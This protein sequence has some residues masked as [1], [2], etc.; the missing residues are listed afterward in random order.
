[1]KLFLG[2]VRGQLL[3]S[4]AA[5]LAILLVVAGFGIKGM[6]DGQAA[7]ESYVEGTAH[8]LTLANDV[9]DAA[10]A[11]A[12]AAR[13]LVLLTTD[14]ERREEQ[15]TVTAAHQK[16]GASLKALNEALR[17]SEPVDPKD[18]ERFE[19]FVRT[20]EQYGPLALEIVRLAVSGD[21]ATATRKMNAECRPLLAT[22]IAQANRFI[23]GT[24]LG[25][26]RRAA[27]AREHYVLMRNLSL[28][29]S[30]L[31]V[32][33]AI[34]LAVILTRAILGALGAEPRELSQAVN[35]VADGDLTAALN[36][37]P[38]DER[39]TMA[40]LRRMR[41][42]LSQLV[43]SVRSNSESVATASAQIAQG[44][45]DLSM[46]T[47]QQAS[48]L[49][50]TAATMDE[51]GTTV[52]NN[53]AN[54]SEASRLATGASQI[55]EQGGQMVDRVVSTMQGISQSS[56]KITEIISVID[57]IAF[58]TNI[59]A[60]NSA[61]EAA[62]AGEQGRG[63]AVVAGEVRTLAQRSAEAAK[64]IKALIHSS[65][66]QVAQGTDLVDAAGKQMVEIVAA[67]RRVT[68][69]VAEISEASREQS[70]GVSQ[71]G[72]AVTEMDQAT[73]Q[74][75]ALV[76]ESTA[77]SESLKQQAQQL[78]QAVSAFKVSV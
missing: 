75:A 17:A 25:A 59:L 57:N 2:T 32:A 7:Y 61:V 41:T 46:R 54:A 6:R 33:V 27:E 53:A 47:E 3:G 44:N 24:R 73:Q 4:Y 51:L 68:D 55:A 31:A 21:S 63:F 78:V 23:E 37:R 69:V 5:L 70:S 50:Q 49:Q 12:I 72:Q 11:R 14:A 35:Q 60:L 22:L 13:N 66:E 16:I 48:A 77:A 39:S 64:E 19:A 38:G 52:Q 36:L 15:A 18:R 58:Q 8:Q 29:V 40:A 43:D 30:A 56:T 71:V 74:N 10:N 28:G 62:R 9:L 42:N 76:E 45:Q 67:I 20:E 65:V 26:E 1:M 34:G